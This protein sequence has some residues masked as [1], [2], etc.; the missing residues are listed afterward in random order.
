MKMTE[1][2]SSTYLLNWNPNKWYWEDLQEC[3]SEIEEYGYREDRWS[4]GTNKKIEFGDRLFIVRL[5]SEP[6]GIFATGWAISNVYEY[7]HWDTSESKKANYIDID[8]D[9]LLNPDKEQI[10]DLA[11]LKSISTDQLWTPQGGGISVRDEVVS[12]LEDTWKEFLNSLGKEQAKKSVEYIPEEVKGVIHYYEGALRQIKVNAYER[13]PK[14]RETCIGHYG[15]SC[16]I[17]GFDFEDVYG[18]V[19]EA[20]IHVHHLKPLADIGESY[21]VDPVQDMRPVC[22]NCHAML[23]RKKSAYTIKEVKDML[24]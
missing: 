9:I 19:G 4:C 3:V 11:T 23:H 16:C 7:E 10:L 6:R 15:F 24:R 8:M 2:T 21:K 13:N 12:P 20:F 18:E 5:G 17:C 22:P 1:P 14:A